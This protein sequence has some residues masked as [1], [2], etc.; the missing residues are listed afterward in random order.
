MRPS[1]V[2]PFVSISLLAPV[3]LL[4]LGYSTYRGIE[5]AT[6]LNNVLTFGNVFLIAAA[7]ASR[8][9]RS[10][11]S[12]RRRP[13][14]ETPE[15]GRREAKLSEH[16]TGGLRAVPPVRS[17]GKGSPE[18]NVFSQTPGIVM[19][20]AC[21]EGSDPEAFQPRAWR[22]LT[23]PFR[24]I[25][26]QRLAQKKTIYLFFSQTPI[27]RCPWQAKPEMRA[28][29]NEWATNM[30]SSRTQAHTRLQ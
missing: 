26:G 21:P 18:R 8:R 7:P 29:T 12:A 14:K 15:A 10:P 19:S 30:Y 22:L 16:L 23:W 13:R 25:A 6:S 27:Q 1:E 28:F 9:A 20:H 4:L 3:F 2:N 5:T 11:L 24:R 17:Q